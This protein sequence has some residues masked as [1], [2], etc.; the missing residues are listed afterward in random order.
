MSTP[1]RRFLLAVASIAVLPA[2][3]VV[4]ATG[5][6]SLLEAAKLANSY[7]TAAAA[8]EERVDDDIDGLLVR[9]CRK[10]AKAASDAARAAQ[11]AIA[12]DAPTAS[13]S[14]LVADKAKA[15]MKKICTFAGVEPGAPPP[16]ASDMGHGA[17]DAAA[18]P[19]PVPTPLPMPA[20]D[21]A[22][23]ARDGGG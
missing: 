12:A 5:C 23:P 6:Q 10:A 13:A 21:A 8:A 9:A 15:R 18:G 1:P 19:A 22:R 16:A 2:L 7:H 11:D 20:P 14:G 17:P 3:C 4:L